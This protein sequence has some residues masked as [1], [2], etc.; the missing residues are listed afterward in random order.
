M[1][2]PERLEHSLQAWLLNL[3]IDNPLTI[4]AAGGS[5]GFLAAHVRGKDVLLSERPVC[6]PAVDALPDGGNGLGPCSNHVPLRFRAV[7]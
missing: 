6:C 3:L 1:F 7:L 2:I 5:K 4:G